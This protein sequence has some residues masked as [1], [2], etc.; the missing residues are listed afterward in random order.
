MNAIQIRKRIE[1]ETLHL[2]ELREMIGKSVQII[3][4]EETERAETPLETRETFFNRRPECALSAEEGQAEQQRL[5]ELAKANPALA[6]ALTIA[7]A[8][9]PD[10]DAVIA[11]RARG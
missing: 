3:I 2:P 8:G 11:Q 7:A 10:V 6:A 4:L 9:G 1:S 5:G